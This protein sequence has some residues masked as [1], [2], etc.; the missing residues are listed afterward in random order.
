MRF[1][2]TER[3]GVI[4]TD[5][6]ITNEI[7][8]IFRE[9]PIADIGVDAII[10]Q[11]EDDEPMGKFLAVQIK[12]GEG[13]FH[14]TGKTLTHYVSS[15]H[16]NYWLNLNIPIVLI[17]H[18]PNKKETY[19]QEIK[20]EN[21]KKN[22]KKWKID[23]PLS[24]KLNDKSKTRLINLL[25]KKNDRSFNIFRG[26]GDIEDP[27]HLIEDVKCIEQATVCIYNISDINKDIT[28]ITLQLK[29]KI[30]YFTDQKIHISDPQISSSFKGYSNSL[31][32]KSRRLENEIELF[33]DLY[34][35]G[36]F[37][38]EKAILYLLLN[39]VKAKDLEVNTTIIDNVPTEIE[40]ALTSY[41][42]LKHAVNSLNLGSPAFKDAKKTYLEVIDLICFEL[43]AA[44]NITESLLKKIHELE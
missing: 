16:Y 41:L 3:Q 31:V 8:W 27:Y 25:S 9:Q 40:V 11:V 18:S 6:I 39:G 44:K 10:E 1:N 26:E 5:R 35:V 36:V 38:F 17:A 7:G 33:S 13:N 12:T 14:M 21:F 29:D 2:K 20:E 32:I 28:E 43:E 42:D 19:W 15:I 30:E 34:S 23:I 37:A 4:E 22:K 24:Q